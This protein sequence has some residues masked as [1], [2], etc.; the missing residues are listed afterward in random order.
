MWKEN[1]WCNFGPTVEVYGDDAII[2][3]HPMTTIQHGEF[4]DIP[5]ITGVVADEGL[6]KTI[7]ELANSLTLLTFELITWY[8]T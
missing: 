5:W 7:G 2:T 1:P 8:F 6:A 3:K 4:R